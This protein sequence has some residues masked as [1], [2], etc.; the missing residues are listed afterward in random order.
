[1][2][3]FLHTHREP[4]AQSRS[5]SPHS[6]DS[7]SGK[8][9]VRFTVNCKPEP[10]LQSIFYITVTVITYALYSTLK[11][12]GTVNTTGPFWTR[13]Q[14]SICTR[15]YKNTIP[16]LSLVFLNNY[17]KLLDRNIFFV[18]EMEWID[19]RTTSFKLKKYLSNWNIRLL[20]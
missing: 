18:T 3:S 13:V 9:M 15:G 1:M 12:T 17:S 2:K 20:S 19:D 6:S 10:L 5:V 11:F 16:W 8:V 7:D 14:N 4:V